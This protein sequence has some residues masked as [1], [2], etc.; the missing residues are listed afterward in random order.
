MTTKILRNIDLN[1]LV[2]LQA[3][4][5]IGHLGK[6]SKKLNLTQSAISHS[7]ARLRDFYGDPLFVRTK[8]GMIPTEFTKKIAPSVSEA[9][10]AITKTLL[11]K[12]S[13]FNP[14]SESR[15]FVIAMGEFFDFILLTD[16][17]AKL[18]AEAPNIRLK[19]AKGFG[20]ENIE[21][22]K[23]GSIHLA[24]EWLP[25]S[26]ADFM[27]RPF[28]HER[29]CLI[30]NKGHPLVDKSFDMSWFHQYRLVCVNPRN[31][32]NAPILNLIKKFAI[33]FDDTL[34][35]QSMMSI[36]QIVAE[37]SHIGLVTRSIAARASKYFPI[38]MVDMDADFPS[39]SGNLIWHH[40][41]DQD[42]GHK[43][44]RK[45]IFEHYAALKNIPFS[46]SV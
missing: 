14:S 41:M 13:S 26:S 45:I 31:H 6:V 11:H 37:S 7:L 1:L 42:E 46:E 9:L 2:V 18:A 5:E 20:L 8:A 4:Y 44:L 25:F 24:L 19:L 17:H 40:S 29:C 30:L 34:K 39:V 3:I 35:V 28:I 38:N 23:E 15:E 16:I 36:P 12:S 21:G 10:T 33:D 22:M 27:S 32:K 43:W